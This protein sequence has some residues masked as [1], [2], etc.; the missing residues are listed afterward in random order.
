MSRDQRP[1]DNWAPYHAWAREGAPWGIAFCL[2][3]DLLGAGPRHYRFM[4]E[5]LVETLR[6]TEAS[7]IRIFLPTGGP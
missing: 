6:A 2:V 1:E 4:L 3:P 7:G 5:G